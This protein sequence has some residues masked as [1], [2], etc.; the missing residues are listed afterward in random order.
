MSDIVY[1]SSLDGT[2]N[3]CAS[4]Y[5]RTEKHALARVDIQNAK[6]KKLGMTAQYKVA[7]TQEDEVPKTEVRD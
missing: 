5:Y 1:F 3:T 7:T 4:A 2:R 6:A